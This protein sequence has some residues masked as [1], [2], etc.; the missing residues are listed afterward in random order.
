MV[1]IL[2]ENRISALRQKSFEGLKSLFFLSLLNNSVEQLPKTSLCHEM[3][4]LNW[5]WTV[6]DD[7]SSAAAQ[8]S[9]GHPL[10][11]HHKMLPTGRR[12]QEAAHRILPSGCCSLDAALRR[13]RKEDALRTLPMGCCPQD[14]V[15]GMLPSRHCPWDAALR[16]LPIGCCPQDIVHGMLPS[17]HCPWDAALKTLSMGCCPQ[18]IVHGMLPSRHCP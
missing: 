5:L 11:L 7:S 8:C 1:R 2:D 13:C 14:I 17:R 15:H 6:R 3:P 10:A 4:R 12:Q 9:V 18:D 16:T